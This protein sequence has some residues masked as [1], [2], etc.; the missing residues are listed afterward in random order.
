MDRSPDYSPWH[1][2]RQ[3]AVEYG[4]DRQRGSL[5]REH[6]TLFDHRIHQHFLSGP[7]WFNCRK[8]SGDWSEE[9]QVPDAKGL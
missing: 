9:R 8:R 5:G 7:H 2:N 4:D 1:G 6:S 3:V